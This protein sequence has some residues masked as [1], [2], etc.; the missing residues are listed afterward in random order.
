MKKLTTYLILLLTLTSCAR[1]PVGADST[2]AHEPT[3]IISEPTAPTDFGF[4]RGVDPRTYTDITFNE[5]EPPPVAPQPQKARTLLIYMNGSDLESETGAGT[6]DLAELCAAGIDESRVN[7]VVLTGGAYRWHTRAVSDTQC[8]LFTL[9]GGALVSLGEIGNR[10]MGDAG[11]LASFI[12]YGATVF[13]AARTS[14]ILWDHGGGSIAGYGADEKFNN[15]VL[16]LREL[17]F[18]FA[19][20]GLAEN[21]LEFLGFDACLMATVET[22]VI[23]APFAELLLASESLEPGDGWDYTALDIL[24]A[25]EIGGETVAAHLADAYIASNCN[26]T[27]EISISVTRTAAAASVMGA[28]GQLAERCA[29]DLSFDGFPRL[30]AARRGTRTFGENDRDT[31]CDMVDI[32]D[33]SASLAAHYPDET[34]NVAAALRAAVAYNA[35]NS[36]VAL[37]G[38]SAYHIFGGVA[39]APHSLAVYADLQMSEPYTR[40]QFDFADRLLRARAALKSPAAQAENRS[41]STLL[42]PPERTHS[43]TL[44]GQ[45]ATLREVAHPRSGT[46]CATACTVNGED[47]DLLVFFPHDATRGTAPALP[48]VLGY[49][50]YDGYLIQ[51]GHEPLKKDDQVVLFSHVAP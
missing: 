19:K 36:D 16:T 30:T 38:L 44:F 39:D 11:T 18:A 25:P 40:Y 14:L 22:A 46:V 51:K 29:A 31:H 2:S 45:S 28:L 37:G 3:R 5:W 17:E 26:T 4:V 33:F 12:R 10:D 34:Q 41:F 47:A 35:H 49:R 13:P 24:N 15:S 23:A 8:E 27:E 48:R 9:R 42:F 6:A 20:A 7:V 21:P 1:L 43:A 50:K 32:A